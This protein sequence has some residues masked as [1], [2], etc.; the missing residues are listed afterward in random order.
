MTPRKAFVHAVKRR[1]IV[2]ELGFSSGK[3]GYKAVCTGKAIETNPALYER[4]KIG[5][6]HLITAGGGGAPLYRVAKNLKQNPHSEILICEH[7]YCVVTADTET[8]QLRTYDLHNQV[9]D[10]LTLNANLPVAANP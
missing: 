4:S 10:T 9:I 8:I 1:H 3:S 6:L 7:S 5:N 2:H